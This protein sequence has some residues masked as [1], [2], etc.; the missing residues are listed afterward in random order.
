MRLLCSFLFALF[1]AQSSLA[2]IALRYED[3]SSL[4]YAE[5][6]ESYR[7][8]AE[9]DKRF[10]FE[11]CGKSDAGE[12]IFVFAPR[13]KKEGLP[14]VLINN[15]IHPGESCGV[16]AS[17]L[18]MNQLIEERSTLLDS[19]NIV[20]IAL[21]NVGGSL[22]RGCCTRANQNGPTEQGFRGNAKNLDLNRDFIKM[23]SQNSLAF[24][25]TFHNWQPDIFIDT[26][27]SNG[28]DYQHCMTLIHSQYDM[29]SAPMAKFCD[30]EILPF[31]YAKMNESYPMAPYMD[32]MGETPEA[33]IKDFADWPRYSNGYAG[34]FNCLGFTTE[35]HMLKPY[36]DRV[37]ATRD[38]LSAMLEFC[39]TS[40][41]RL[42]PEVKLIAQ[43]EDLEQKEWCLDYTLDKTI[44][45]SVNFMG[46]SSSKEPSKVTGLQRLK[47]H[48]DKPYTK[49][50]SQFSHYIG[51]DTVM[52]PSHYLI[53]TAWQEVIARLKLNKV[54]MTEIKKDSNLV[55]TAYY[56]SHV[57]SPKSPYEGHFLHDNVDT[58]TEQITVNLSTGYMLIPTDQAAR[59][60]L[61]N[62]LEPRAK[63]SFFNWNFFD[64]VLQ[65]KEWFSPYVFED[66]AEEI[67]SADAELKAS[68]EQKRKEEEGFKEDMWGQLMY[69]YKHSPYYEK[70]HLRYPVFRLD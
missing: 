39:M 22:N 14:T 56:I 11:P 8:L 66:L 26:H 44:V 6:I 27:T 38:F 65:Q 12:D 69:I 2:Q 20:I 34:L 18:L 31:L 33:G 10:V 42:L 30:R 52:V 68:F 62:V 41:G 13:I 64:A 16:D 24:T 61:I 50:I 3:N 46:Y 51:S 35:A 70:S 54:D 49:M 63:D 48:R 5:T 25:E 45:D 9:K 60:Y 19:I 47:Y 37:L 32:L 36:Q 43:R 59:R 53:P 57:D 28:A 58:R 1:L 7:Y 4:N 67:L 15:G 23:D 21:Y 29:I 55:A 17:I 40:R